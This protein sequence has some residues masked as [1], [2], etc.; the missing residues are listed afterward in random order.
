MTPPVVLDL[1]GSVGP[2]PGA[3]VVALGDWQERIRF[4]CGMRVYNEF[5]RMLRAALPAAHGT[6]FLGSGDF[7][8][9]SHTLIARQCAERVFKVVVLDNHPDNM[10]FPFGIHCGSWIRRVAALPGVS[11]VHVLGITSRDVAVAH[12]W[13]NYFTPLLRGRLT[14]WCIGVDVGWARRLGLA[15]RFRAFDSVGAMLD[16]F[17]ESEKHDRTMTYLSIDKDVLSPSS[18]RTNWDQGCMT[19]HELL[20]TIPLFRGRLAGADVTGDVSAHCYKTRWK[21]WM[22]ALDRRPSVD[23]ESLAAWQREHRA[24]NV[25]LLDA[26]HACA[27]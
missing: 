14:N 1:D 20:D 3:K 24:L 22:S 17:A 27:S 25:R 8:H 7:H 23:G 13:E 21:R 15:A 6:V 12:A 9:I 16:R 2:L 19:E 11:H 26:L 5:A 10:R 4:A 18:A